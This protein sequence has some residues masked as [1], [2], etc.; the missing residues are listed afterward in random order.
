MNEE[1]FKRLKGAGLLSDQPMD[2]GLVPTGSMALNMVVSGKYD[3][4]IPVGGIT[5]VKGESSTAKTVFVTGILRAAQKKG[6]YA[7]LA[8]SENAYNVDFAKRLGIDPTRLFYH[9]PESIEESFEYIENTINQIRDMDPDTPIVVGYDSIAVSPTRKE[10][11]GEDYEQSQIDGAYRAKITGGCLRKINPILRKKKVAL[12]I[13]NQLRSKV[14]VMY[15]SPDTNAAGGRALE[16]YLAVDLKTISNK[17]S[18][19]LRN[20]NKKIIGIR[21]TV[22]NTKNKVSMPYRECEFELMYDKGLT[23]DFGLL[24]SLVEEGHISKNGAWYNCGDKKFQNMDSFR[25]LLEDKSLEEFDEVRKILKVDLTK[26]I[27]SL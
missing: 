4:G 6:Y 18:D 7:V 25:K 15:G 19:L 23:E 12:V 20:E 3:G 22:R 24:K 13:V 2:L 21:G 11:K 1:V 27:E 17:T 10:L 14:G 26:K 9:A 16:Y 5:Q 8:D